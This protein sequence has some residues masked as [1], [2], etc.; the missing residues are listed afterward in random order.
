MSSQQILPFYGHG[1]GTEYCEFSNFYWH[2]QPYEFK[3]PQCCRREGLPESV[4]CWFSET[5]IMVS[6]AALFD[7]KEIFH[8]MERAMTP[9]KVKGLGRKVRNFDDAVWKEHLEEIAFEVVFQKFNSARRLREVLLKTGEKTIVEAAPYDYVW[10]VGLARSDPRVYDPAQWQGT[11][12]LGVALMQARDA[13]RKKSGGPVSEAAEPSDESS[14]K[15]TRFTRRHK[16]TKEEQ[17]KPQAQ[18]SSSA[19]PPDTAAA[20]PSSPEA[21]EVLKLEKK[22]REV[23]K[24][25][26]RLDAGE[27]LEKLQ[28]QK[29]LGRSEIESKLAE[30]QP[31]KNGS[32]DAAPSE[33]SPSADPG[34]ADFDSFAVLDFEATCEQDVQMNP[35]EIIEFPIVLVDGQ[36]LEQV[37]E[38]RTYVLPESHPKLTKFCMDLTGIQQTD[39]DSAPRWTD[40]LTSAQSWLQD[41][42]CK[43][44]YKR[45]LFVT[46]GDW[47]LRQMLPKQCSLHQQPVPEMFTRWLNVKNLFDAVTSRGKQGMAGM[48]PALDL[49]LIGRHHCGLDDCRNIA[50]ILSELLRRGGKISDSMISKLKARKGQGY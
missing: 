33:S 28:L 3:L 29:L 6:K 15:R 34:S 45:C 8:E 23:E 36:T 42:L 4:W 25:Q 47:D 21:K 12:V 43:R 49:Q 11:N 41:Q 9:D 7:D 50:R 22:L 40:A 30:L 39:V 37:D 31:K 32:V 10:G 38:F 26:Q 17:E 18:S 13:L 27:E 1:Y 19:M 2:K 14:T 5:A 24:L 20:A 48:L 35:Q 44:G 16:E 46:C